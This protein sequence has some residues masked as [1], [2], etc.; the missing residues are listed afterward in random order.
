MAESQFSL[1]QVY[2]TKRYNRKRTKRKPRKYWAV[3][4]AWRQSLHAIAIQP[5]GQSHV[6][7]TTLI[8][9]ENYTVR[10]FVI[11]ILGYCWK[12]HVL[13]L[14]DYSYIAY[15]GSVIYSRVP[16]VDVPLYN[17][18]YKRCPKLDLFNIN[19]GSVLILGKCD[20]IQHTRSQQWSEAWLVFCAFLPCIKF[21][22]RTC[23]IHQEGHL[24]DGASARRTL[25]V[26]I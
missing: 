14:L 8:V 21:A 18:I 2:R 23:V 6:P 10:L 3:L 17:D 26:H 22:F 16:R 15:Y 11:T 24:D 9:I 20:L 25:T 4:N 1:P 5:A 13:L 19:F 12:C 7:F